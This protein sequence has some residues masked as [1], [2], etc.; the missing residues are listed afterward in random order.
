LFQAFSVE[1][2]SKEKCVVATPVDLGLEAS[3]VRNLAQRCESVD[4]GPSGTKH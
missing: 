2:F 1:S 3:Q 4:K